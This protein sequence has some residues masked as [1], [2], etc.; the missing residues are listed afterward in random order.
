[1]R[2][3]TP[4]LI[5][6][7]T[8]ALFCKSE[9]GLRTGGV[10]G[11][12]PDLRIREQM[13]KERAGLGSVPGG[14]AKRQAWGP[15]GELQGRGLCCERWDLEEVVM[16]FCKALLCGLLRRHL[17]RCYRPDPLAWDFF[18]PG[19]KEGT[20]RLDFLPVSLALVLRKPHGALSHIL[21][22][23]IVFKDELRREHRVGKSGG[24]PR[25]DRDHGDP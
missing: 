7:V 3:G 2:V 12:R 25:P 20:D 13:G 6:L 23:E 21:Y 4:F 14:P 8:F 17:R 10:R 16:S 11:S 19:L 1:M 15:R 5:K 22:K 24:R 18:K 9:Q